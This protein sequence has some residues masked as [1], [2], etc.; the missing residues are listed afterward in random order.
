MSDAWFL[1]NVFDKTVMWSDFIKSKL[2]CRVCDIIFGIYGFDK[3]L[4]PT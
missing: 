2:V 1:G 4:R 3:V